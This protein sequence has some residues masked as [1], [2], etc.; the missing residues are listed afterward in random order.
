MYN[1][2]IFVKRVRAKA[3]TAYYRFKQNECYIC[4]RKDDLELHHIIPL[5]TIVN[6]YIKQHGQ[7]VKVDDVIKNCPEIVAEDN[8]VTLCKIHHYYLHNLFG[9]EFNRKVAE[10]TKNYIE[11][12]RSKNYGK[13]H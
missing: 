5:A 1:E 7:E 3:K 10:K 11:K 4:G 8:V 12:Q 6:E 9:K 2:K 13:I